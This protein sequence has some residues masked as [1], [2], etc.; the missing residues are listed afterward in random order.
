MCLLFPHK[1]TMMPEKDSSELW[2]VISHLMRTDGAGCSWTAS[3]TPHHMIT[4]AQGELVEAAEEIEKVS[5]LQVHCP[6]SPPSVRVSEDTR[7]RGGRGGFSLHAASTQWNASELCH[8][9]PRIEM[10]RCCC[11]CCCCC[12]CVCVFVRVCPSHRQ[13]DASAGDEGALGE[14]REALESELGD[15]LFDTYMLIEVCR[16][17]GLG[18]T[19]GGAVSKISQKIRRRCPQ[20]FSPSA[21]VH[22]VDE[23]R[24]AWEQAKRQENKPLGSEGGAAAHAVP[25]TAR[26]ACAGDV[27]ILAAKY[28]TLGR[29]KTRLIPELGQEGALE[30]ATALLTD[31]IERVSRA[32]CLGKASKVLLFAPADAGPKLEALLGELGVR[33]QW[34]LIPMVQ[35][36]DLT[37][38]DLG[39]KLAAG[40]R[41][42]RELPANGDASITNRGSAVFLGMDVP[43]LPARDVARALVTSREAACAFICPAFDGG[44]TMLSLPPAASRKVCLPVVVV[45][46]GGDMDL[47][48][49]P[50]C[51]DPSSSPTACVSIPPCTTGV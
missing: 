45:E 46:V 18:V 9:T 19:F 32:P 15:V 43:E 44:Y 40:L 17:D 20:V 24:V 22:S 37:S 10:K 34:D 35:A 41:A 4:Y 36:S 51:A 28:P 29:S 13:H 6:I 33:A 5:H 11:S 8:Q 3:R 39:A 14:A 2:D 26:S 27:V 21:S 12:C 31:Q 50:P 25:Q 42:A 1:A 7:K 49:L 38:P 47:S 30:V 16:R 23:A 48:A